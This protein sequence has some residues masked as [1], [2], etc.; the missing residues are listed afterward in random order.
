MSESEYQELLKLIGDPNA[1]T[2]KTVDRVAL[3]NEYEILKAGKKAVE[4]SLIPQDQHHLYN[5]REVTV[6]PD[7]LAFLAECEYPLSEDEVQMIEKKM[8]RVH[9]LATPHQIGM[10]PRMQQL[11]VPYE[12]LSQ[13]AS[14]GILTGF[15][16][17][18][19]K[20]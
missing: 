8:D 17:Y 2:N 3:E 18:H 4:L 11:G 1:K 10:S 7:V 19:S 14:E 13:L 5:E 6:P 12:F 20:E 16:Y 15:S 9:N